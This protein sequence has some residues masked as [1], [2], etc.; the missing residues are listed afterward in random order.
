MYFM[1]FGPSRFIEENKKERGAT[2][3]IF[4]NLGR[5]ISIFL[6]LERNYS[7]VNQIMK[8]DLFVLII[9]EY[10]LTC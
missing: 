3:V 9:I 6:Y 10:S 1:N 8:N 7:E 2:L 4:Y 5:Y